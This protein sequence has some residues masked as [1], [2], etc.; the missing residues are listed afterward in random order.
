MINLYDILEAADG[1]L[2]GEA[3]AVLFT[4]FC[5]DS[6]RVNA[7]ELFVAVKTERGDGHQYMREAVQG[8]A[9]GIMCQRPPDFDTAGLTVIVM[10]DVEAALL[11]W[12]RIVIRKFGTTIIGVTGS[13]GKTTAKEA[14][15]AVL[16]TKYRVYKSFGSYNGRFGL[17][18]TLGKL[19][20]ED[21]LAVLEFG[22]DHFGEMSELVNVT[23]P[24]VG[25]VTNIS[26]GYTDRLG[27]LNNIAAEH[28]ILIEGLPNDGLAV[29]NYDDDLV[30]NMAT[31]TKAQ[32][33]TV[34]LDRLGSA[35]GADFIAYNLLVARDKTGFDLRHARER[36]VGHWVALLGYHQLYSVLDALAV[37]FA[38]DVPIED[39]LRALTEL[40]ALPGRMNPLEG[41]G[42]SLIVDD[43][44]NANPESTLAAL[45]WLS[46]I[47]RPGRGRMIFVLGDMDELGGHAIAGHRTVG[48]RAS[49]VADVFVTEG[50]LA[51]VAGRAALD[52]GMPR[53]RVKITFSPQDAAN[54]LADSLE[55]DDVVLI[56]GSPSA[57]MENVTRLLLAREED[58]KLLPRQESAYASVWTNRPSRPTWI[59][60]DRTAIAHNVRLIKEIIGPDVALM[61]VVKANA[62]GHGAVAVSTTALLNGA[63]YLGVASLNEA[64]ELRE[65][66]I[67]APILVLGYTPP[68]LV[69]QA[70]RYNLTLTLY[71]LEM[72]RSYDRVAR[73]MNMTLDIHV[74]VDT[75]MSRLGLL[76]DQVMPFFR[77][78]RNLRNL[79]IEGIFTHF[80]E[81]EA[82]IPFTEEQLSTFQSI[83]KPLRAGGYEFKYIHAG[84]TA[85]AL[86]LPDTRLN[87]VR[88]GLGLYGLSPGPDFPMPPGFRPAMT[89]KTT[90][91]QVKTLPPGVFVG[92]NKTYRT[93]T[94]ERIA[95]IPVGYADGFRRAPKTWGHVLVGGQRAPI[96]GR[97][98]MDM[99][100]INVTDI[101]GVN[102]GDEVVL[103]GRQGDQQITADD[104]AQQ[105]ETNNYE[106]IST[107]LARVPRV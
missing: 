87:M 86:N 98:S 54:V 19:T 65:A 90:I 27:D 29:L 24:L 43:T 104:V 40:P 1:Q 99:T 78:L 55:A 85:A 38:Y 20:G 89:W 5:Y 76:P 77:G 100:M 16:G 105:L 15:A 67:D 81:S 26:H 48:K 68:W 50:E 93:R 88:V 37:G 45:D 92:Y 7:G 28:G 70:L 23:K 66:A 12:A 69:R 97:V 39:G 11:R 57:R 52:Q 80:A 94:T 32:I 72:A 22:T 34:G 73:E 46:A 62:F 33:Q 44:F 74:K 71:D 56:K 103:I 9:T 4:D 64:M 10:R 79:H 41:K 49:E 6:R 53:Y 42:G 17:P 82:D 75:G 84:N 102:I 106:V 14:I 91:A 30:R 107:I 2:F 21:K 58:A 25:V 3:A 83:L 13:A 101:P 18:L 36:Y 63:S 60:I 96:V 8:G 51:A 61:A 47:R 95:V 59:E 35:F 31:R